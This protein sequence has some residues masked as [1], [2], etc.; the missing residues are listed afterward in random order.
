MIS[1]SVVYGHTVKYSYE[2]PNEYVSGSMEISLLANV[3][4]F[5]DSFIFGKVNSSY[6]F[7]VAFFK[8]S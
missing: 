8:V 7:R 4:I 2:I 6:F 3:V 5:S 1:S